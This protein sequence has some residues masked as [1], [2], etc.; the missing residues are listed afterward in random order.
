M[1][2]RLAGLGWPEIEI[3]DDDL[4]I[5]AAGSAARAGF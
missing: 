2:E 4:G 3:I 1:R 5:P